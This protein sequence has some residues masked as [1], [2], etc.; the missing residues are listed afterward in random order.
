MYKVSN[1]LFKIDEEMSK[2]LKLENKIK[3]QSKKK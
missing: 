3:K 2:T 1:E